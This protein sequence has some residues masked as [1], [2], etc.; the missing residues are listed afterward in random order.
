MRKMMT[1][2]LSERVETVYADVY[3]YPTVLA[4]LLLL[5]EAFIPEAKRRKPFPKNDAPPA[6]PPRR[7]ARARA[8][9]AATVSLL[10]LLAGG[11]DDGLFVR[12]SPA[13]DDAIRSLDAGDPAAASDV[14]QKYLSTG[15]CS[16]DKF[17]T[18]DSVRSRTNA[19]FDLGLALF[20]VAEKFGARF[21]EDPKGAALGA[22]NPVPTA[23][24]PPSPGGPPGP[25]PPAGPDPGA[26]RAEGVDCALRVVR[27]VA[28]DAAAP[29]D[30]KAKAE[31]LTGNLEFLRGNYKDAVSSYD[32][33]LKLLPARKEDGEQSVGARAAWNRAIALR[34]IEEEEK[35]P[36]AGKPP[37]QPDGGE[38]QHQ[39][40]G[41][42]DD[43]KK[44]DDKKDDQKK[45]DDKKDDQKKNDDKK[46]DQKKDDDKKDDD[47]KNQPDQKNDDK[48][49]SQAEN[50]PEQKKP[51]PS[52]SQDERMLDNLEQ[53]P[54]VQ[55][56]DAKRHAN[57]ARVIGMEDK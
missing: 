42:K 28:N 51:P 10:A 22:G 45:D 48:E 23:G 43:Q 21:G 7:S 25:A 26:R 8:A 31:Y 37:P 54:T 41:K 32:A 33:A 5:V 17:S 40:G 38:P 46:D 36:D 4:L 27:I 39:D 57:R 35:K 29:V 34:R 14:L 52:L 11:C 49:K 44:D 2:E 53:A 20:R 55:Q 18:P 19:S 50:K 15:E 56:E 16:G 1:E 30:L 3:V 6:P 13:V 12:H 24:A 47:K 9:R